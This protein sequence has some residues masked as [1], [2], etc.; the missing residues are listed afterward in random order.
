MSG[1]RGLAPDSGRE[2]AGWRI[3]KIVGPMDFGLVGVLAEAS[4]ILAGAGVPI[5]AIST[6]DTDYILV[7][8]ARLKD[9]IEAL[10]AG[11]HVV[12]GQTDPGRER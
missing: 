7:K 6:F 3:L 5:F 9:A 11:G 2:E 12:A 4:G 8:Q 1:G 10:R